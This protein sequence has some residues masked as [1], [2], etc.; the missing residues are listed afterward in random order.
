MKKG[1]GIIRISDAKSGGKIKSKATLKSRVQHNLRGEALSKSP[2]LWH[3][4]KQE[5]SGV[6]VLHGSENVDDVISVANSAYSQLDIKPTEGKSKHR[7]SVHA[8]EILCAFSPDAQNEICVEQWADDCV[9]FLKQ[10]FGNRL[11][12]A[13]MHYD[14][15]TPHLHAIML[16]IVKDKQ[17]RFKLNASAWFNNVREKQPD[18][19]YKTVVNK[20]EKLQ[21]EFYVAVSKKHGLMRGE[22]VSSHANDDNY[23]PPSHEQIQKMRRR[24][25]IA[26]LLAH[27]KKPE[28]LKNAKKEIAGLKRKLNREKRVAYR[29]GKTHEAKRFETELDK[30]KC[31]VT[32]LK[33]DIGITQ[34]K[35]AK[36]ESSIDKLKA[37]NNQLSALVPRSKKRHA[38]NLLPQPMRRGS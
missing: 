19:K 31:T 24:S 35:N 21:D 15:S 27:I 34:R 30:L 14:E 8:V 2:R 7:D 33:N 13:V 17:N 9:G 12:S 32:K 25:E 38:N 16:P 18:G 29:A 11:I 36:L 28:Q 10:K 22:K 26:T 20:M 5:G 23:V 1:Y 4:N 6:E 3:I 37:E